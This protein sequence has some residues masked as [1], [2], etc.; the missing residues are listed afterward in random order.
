MRQI[1]ARLMN[2]AVSKRDKQEKMLGLGKQWV[3][4]NPSARL[5]PWSS[6]SQFPSSGQ[7]A[8][9]HGCFAK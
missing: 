6:G 9:S 8:V 5:S 1:S 3:R 4:V 2:I 7:R